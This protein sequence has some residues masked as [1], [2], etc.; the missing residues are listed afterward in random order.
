MTTYITPTERAV[1]YGIKAD[2]DWN[3]LVNDIKNHEE[4][5]SAIESMGGTVVVSSNIPLGGILI[6]SGA[7]VNIPSGWSLCDGGTVN[8]YVTPD[9][10]DR[11][12]IGAGN[13]YAVG[14]TGGATTHTHEGGSLSS[15]GAHTHTFSGTTGGPSDNRAAISGSLSVATS[16]HTH[17]F[18]G[19]TGSSGSHTHSTETTGSASSLPPYY[20]LAFIMRTS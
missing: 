7:V 14:K 17:T 10:R 16:S 4:R 13:N 6:W 1:A 12:V 9:L 2:A 18:S 20:A 11:F 15:S 8:G 5:I 3:V 19:T